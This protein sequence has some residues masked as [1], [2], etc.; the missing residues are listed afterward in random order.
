M[1]FNIL[2][3]TEQADLSTEKR[4][5]EIGGNSTAVTQWKRRKDQKGK[6]RCSMRNSSLPV[7][8]QH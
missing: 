7:E 1:N 3:K 5:S 8:G 4:P 6:G 2:Q